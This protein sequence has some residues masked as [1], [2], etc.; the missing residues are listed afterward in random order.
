MSVG[1]WH[2]RESHFPDDRDREA[3]ERPVEYML[4]DP[5][6]GM[7][8][9]VRGP[10]DMTARER[11]EILRPR[12]GYFA[13]AGARPHLQ[14][15][16]D[17]DAGD[18]VH[19]A[20]FRDVDQR[21]QWIDTNM[22]NLYLRPA[23]EQWSYWAARLFPMSE[24]VLDADVIQGEAGALETGTGWLMRRLA[25]GAPGGLTRSRQRNLPPGYR[26]YGHVTGWTSNIYGHYSQSYPP[27]SVRRDLT[28]RLRPRQRYPQMGRPY[29]GRQDVRRDPFME[30]LGTR[31]QG[32]RQTG[33]QL[34][35]N[36]LDRDDV[37][38]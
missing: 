29:S 36:S 20:Y 5:Y 7:K 32:Q 19:G 9:L 18:L 4:H 22:N 1:V 15:V 34:D 10:R 21:E 28:T 3:P 8:G 11:G 14:A 26:H 33:G 24:Q 17:A 38:H 16:D 35:Y 25:Y 30:Y 23:G 6:P 31:P 13:V 37:L 2:R 27:E 12:W